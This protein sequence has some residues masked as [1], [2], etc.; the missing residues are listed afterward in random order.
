MSMGE[1]K[2]VAESSEGARKATGEDSATKAPI[3]GAV[4]RPNAKSPSSW[5][6]SAEKIWKPSAAATA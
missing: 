1:K 6:C 2:G 3:L 5:N 4:G